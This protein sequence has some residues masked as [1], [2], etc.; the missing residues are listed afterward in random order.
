MSPAKEIEIL[1]DMVATIGNEYEK[2]VELSD[3]PDVWLLQVITFITNS[4]EKEI[5]RLS[6][7][8]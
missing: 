6:Q 2:V 8:E 4:C 1:Q 5:G 7:E 3:K